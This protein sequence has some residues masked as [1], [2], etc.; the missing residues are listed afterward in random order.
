MIDEPGI[1]SAHTAFNHGP[2]REL[3]T[4]DVTVADV[5]PLAPEAFL[6]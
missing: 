1:V 5:T 2:V 4:P 6:I 3:E